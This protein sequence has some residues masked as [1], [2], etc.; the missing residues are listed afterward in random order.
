MEL[1]IQPAIRSNMNAVSELLH[2]NQLPTEDIFE[3]KIKFFI[4][5]INNVI[6]GTIGVEKYQHTGLQRSLAVDKEFRN[7]HIGKKLL[8]HLFDYCSAEKIRKLYL[9]TTTAEEYFTR[10]G[11][12]KIDRVNIPEV[13]SQTK[14]FQD[15]CP[16]TATTMYKKQ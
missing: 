8:N 13:I 15:I 2:D 7:L 10:F 5:L 6:V 12:Q 14:E 16:L 3:Q 11:F 9:L 4:A 1:V